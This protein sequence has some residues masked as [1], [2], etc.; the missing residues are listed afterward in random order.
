M[1]VLQNILLVSQLYYSKVIYKLYITHIN[2]LYMNYMSL[3][4]THFCSD[5]KARKQLKQIK[6]FVRKQF[7]Q[8]QRQLHQNI[9]MKKTI[10][11]LVAKCDKLQRRCLQ[12][13]NDI[14]ESKAS[15]TQL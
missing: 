7:L 14:E 10:E 13:S 4:R 2:I 6:I 12:L 9:G 3:R 15:K 8:N 1:T 5:K 11:Q